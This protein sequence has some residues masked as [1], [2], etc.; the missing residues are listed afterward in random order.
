MLTRI[1]IN[2]LLSPDAAAGG[3][4]S[5]GTAT[6]G[7][8][9]NA[10]GAGGDPAAAAGGDDDLDNQPPGSGGDPA[11]D[12]DAAGDNAD[13]GAADG[14][15][16]AGDG[17]AADGDDAA[18]DGRGISRRDLQDI[19]Q[20]VLPET[21]RHATAAAAPRQPP[22]QLTEE[23]YNRAFNVYQPDEQ[24]INDLR[25]EDPKVAVRAITK[26][27]DGLIRQ[28]M[29][30][31][32]TRVQMIRDQLLNEHITP[33]NTYVT[34]QQAASFRSDFFRKYPD[35]EPYETIVDAVAAKLQQ[36]G[37][38]ASSRDD[39]FKRYASESKRAV[40]VLLAKANKTGQGKTGSAPQGG[41]RMS[42][43]SGGGQGGS[44]RP[45]AAAGAKGPA[46]IEIF[47]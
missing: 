20:A 1:L 39:A 43:L 12:D 22:Q 47:D 29:T 31:A 30:M 17:D 4:G 10:G 15:A 13:G 25:S 7:A 9:A 41:K 3:G 45:G 8:G 28:A 42:T 33:I 23:E 16:A 27:R 24:L 32:E 38:T 19:L 14:D 44:S 11:A 26:L 2:L 40:Q 36:N 37:F 5:A 18:A 21:V 34:E 46:G 6:A 35:L